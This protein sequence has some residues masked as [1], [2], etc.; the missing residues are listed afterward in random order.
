MKGLVALLVVGLVAGVAGRPADIPGVPKEF[1]NINIENY[2]RNAKAVQ[3]QL[4]CVIYEGPCDTIGKYLKKNIPSWLDTQCENCD[5]EQ[6]TQA[7]KLINFFQENYAKEWDDAIKKYGKTKFTDEEIAK[8]ESELG[9]KINRDPNAPTRAPGTKPDHNKLA[10][11]AKESIAVLK[12]TKEP[13]ILK[14][15]SSTTIVSIPTD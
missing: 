6:K 14:K 15:D 1:Q 10:E 7:S 11:L 5:G 4:K 2:L 9:V 13:L 12:A 3:F 8:F